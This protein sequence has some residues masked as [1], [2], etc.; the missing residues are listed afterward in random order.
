VAV[1]RGLSVSALI[2]S[3]S[4]GLLVL[5]LLVFGLSLISMTVNGGLDWV[6]GI[7]PPELMGYALY[8]GPVSGAFAVPLALLGG[9]LAIAAAVRDATQV[10]TILALCIDGAVLLSTLIIACVSVI[11]MAGSEVLF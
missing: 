9:G 7:G 1:K 11:Q 8:F 3:G 2:V 4:A 6:A 5:P 10:A